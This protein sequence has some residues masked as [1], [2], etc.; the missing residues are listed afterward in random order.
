MFLGKV[1]HAA[2]DGLSIHLAPDAVGTLFGVPITNTLL[3]V[4]LTMAILALLAIFLNRGLKEVPGK[5]QNF[6]E[7]VIGAVFDYM[8]DVLESRTLAKRFF[9]LVMTIFL[10]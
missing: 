1:A 2:E 6:F 8:S 4:W 3:S 5:L 9:P 10:F 7:L